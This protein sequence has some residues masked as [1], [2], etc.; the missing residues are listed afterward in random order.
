MKDDF[1]SR[2]RC[3]IWLDIRFG[4]G[5]YYKKNGWGQMLGNLSFKYFES[6]YVSEVKVVGS[7][8]YLQKNFSFFLFILIGL[9]INFVIF[10]VMKKGF[11]L[12]RMFIVRFFYIC[13]IMFI[14]R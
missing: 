1:N 2:E 7:W 14:S 3:F 10:N 9:N 11:F 13:E 6:L 4:R 8:I 5:V 12:E